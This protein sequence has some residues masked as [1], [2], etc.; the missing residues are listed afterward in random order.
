MAPMTRTPRWSREELPEDLAELVATLEPNPTYVVGARWDV[1]HANATAERV[2]TP[3][4]RLPRE[5]RNLLWFYCVDPAARSLFV[6]WEAEARLQLAH[7][8]RDY[9]RYDADPAFARLLARVTAAHPPVEQWW[10]QVRQAPPPA[11]RGGTKTVRV[12]GLAARGSAG[13][14]GADAAVVRLRQLVLASVD[15]PDVKVITYFADLDE[16]EDSRWDD[17]DT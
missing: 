4:S 8:H 12:A 5:R 3:W 9:V 6:D 17:L 7:F 10:D 2:F 1:L 16:D 13:R 14:Q 11:T 15:D